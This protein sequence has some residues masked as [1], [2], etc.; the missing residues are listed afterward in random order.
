MFFFVFVVKSTTTHLGFPS[1][2]LFVLIMQT[3]DIYNAENVMYLLKIRY[4]LNKS[5]VCKCYLV[6]RSDVISIDF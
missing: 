1:S 4:C 2:I 3:A 5:K 6:T